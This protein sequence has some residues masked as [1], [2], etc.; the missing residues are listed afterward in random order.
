MENEK[1]RAV[2]VSSNRNSERPS[3]KCY[4][5]GSEDHMIANFPN[6]PKDNE[7]Q[8]KQVRFNEKVNRGYNKSEDNDDHKIYASM[9]QMSSDD[10]RKSGEY[11][12]SSKLT[13]YIL[14]SRATFHMTPEVTDFIPGSL[15]D[16]DKYIEV[17]DIN[18]V[19]AKQ[20]GSVRI[21]TCDDNGKKFIA[22]LYNVLLATDLR[23]R[24]FS[25]ITLMNAGHTCIFQKEFCTVYFGA[26]ENNAVTLLHGAQ[27]KHA[28][29]G[30][31]KDVSKKNK[32]P[33]RKKIA[34][35]L[36]HQRLGHRSTRSLLAGDT[37]NVWE[38]VDLRIYPDTFCT[39][40]QISSMNKKARSKIPLKPKAPFKWVFM[41]IISSTAP[42]IL[43]SDTMFYNYLLIVDAYSKIPKRYGMGNIKTE[44][45]MDKLDMFQSR[46]GKMDQFGWWYLERISAHADTQ[47]TLTEFKDES[48]PRGF[49][50]TLV[51]PEHQDM[52]GQVEVTWRTL[53]TVAHALMVHA[54]VPKVY[55]HF[56]LMYTTDH[57]FPVLPIK[58]LINED[59]N[60][61]MPHKLATGTKPSVSHLR[62]LFCLCVVRKATAHVETKTLNMR[63][64][65]QKAFCG[66]FV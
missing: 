43:T 48:Q 4:R 18:H 65:A 56:A 46:F 9:A 15:E 29:K 2:D 57:I 27:R 7:K 59:G 39:S 33:A 53:R 28:F 6:P 23:D 66:I 32:Y 14:D 52:N 17:A 1:S 47:F 62:V 63:H 50:L 64:Q 30:K 61:T 26:K 51:P 45:V 55:V 31:I 40:C 42:K 34:L 24:L 10:E 20:K 11:G 44:E 38:D 54:I 16:T 19:T 60:T 22:T 12:D 58:D 3:Q 36:L 37:A 21:Q 5:C 8:R 41:D 49:H 13:N 35:E 25:I